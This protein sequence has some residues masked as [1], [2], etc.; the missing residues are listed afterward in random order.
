MRRRLAAVAPPPRVP[1][2]PLALALARPRP[3]AAL[4]LLAANSSCVPRQS[5]GLRWMSAGRE[6]PIPPSAPP[7]SPSRL[8]LSAGLWNIKY[9]ETPTP[10]SPSR[11]TPTSTPTHTPTASITPSLSSTQTRTPTV[12]PSVTPTT[13]GTPTVSPTVSPT[14]VPQWSRATA[15]GGDGFMGAV[16]N[17]DGSVMLGCAPGKIVRSA[18]S[19]ATWSTVYSTYK[20]FQNLNS[21]AALTS[22]WASTNGNW[23]YVSRDLGLTFTEYSAAPLSNTN[24]ASAAVSENGN[25]VALCTF[26]GSMYVSTDGGYVFVARTGGDMPSVT[27]NSDG[28]RIYTIH[29]GDPMKVTTN[30]GASF[31]SLPNSWPG[32]ATQGAPAN[33]NANAW[34]W[35]GVA[36]STDGTKIVANGRSNTFSAANYQGALISVSLDSGATWTSPSFTGQFQ[37][38]YHSAASATGEVMAVTSSGVAAQGAYNNALTIAVYVSTNSGS[39]WTQH[40]PATGGV[41]QTSSGWNPVAVSANGK[42]ILAG[43]AYLWFYTR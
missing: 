31:T 7:S 28:T 1:L 20:N 9:D 16:L 3:S 37:D 41:S 18:D 23:V 30:Y 15:A 34:H 40:I 2:R 32:I 10:T 24:F 5:V 36:T 33:I 43:S 22:I 13:S 19:G 25:V 21:N 26:G 42:V 12:T 27:M 8:I 29:R 35:Y 11:A 39:T 14:A 4:E 17:T 38:Y 6:P